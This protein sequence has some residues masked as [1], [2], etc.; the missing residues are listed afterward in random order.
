M[1]IIQLP[2]NVS[3]RIAAGEVIERPASVIRELLDNAIDANADTIKI[4]ISDGGKKNLVM[5]DNG[6]GMDKNDLRLCSLHHTTSKL[7][8]VNDLDKLSSLGFRGEAL[9]SIAAVSHMQIFSRTQNQ[10]YGHKITV[11]NDKINEPEPV[12]C[13][14]G[15]KIV[16]NE[17]FYNFPARL[18]F[19]KTTAYEGKLIKDEVLYKTLSFPYL[20]ISLFHNQK[21]VFTHQGTSNALDVVKNGIL[22]T[23]NMPEL[24]PVV[25]ETESIRISGWISDSSYYFRQRKHQYF[26]VNQRY[27]PTRLFYAAV[28]NAINSYFIKGQYP[29]LFL[30]LTIDPAEIDINVHPAKREIKF[31][32]STMIFEAVS[33]SLKQ[34]FQKYYQSAKYKSPGLVNNDFP[35]HKPL[36]KL[37]PFTES[38]EQNNES[39]YANL[40]E[41]EPN[42]TLPLADHK[43]VFSSSSNTSPLQKISIADKI[44][45]RTNME[46]NHFSFIGYLNSTYLLLEQNHDLIIIDQHAAHER[47]I[48]EE[49]KQKWDKN[50]SEN[51]KRKSYPLLTPE[52]IE[53]EKPLPNFDK[54]KSTFNNIGFEIDEYGD[55]TIILR[56]VPEFLHDNH[57]ISFEKIL[58]TVITEKAN[59]IDDSVLNIDIDK[60]EK[61]LLSELSCQKAVKK[62]RILNILEIEQL[63]EKII[64]LNILH[65][66]H[67]RP[68]LKRISNR[69][70]EQMFK[71]IQ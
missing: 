37:T 27:M 26:F 1:K 33:S 43:S 58:K 20:N 3:S 54:I 63:I 66:P 42:F 21:P 40:Q 22:M 4:E 2:K 17:L 38:E 62:G 28:D 50:T 44:T 39:P 53:L 11:S 5:Q 60:I 8:Q 30:Y 7:K 51:N 9:A 6:M 16:I 46:Q 18:K 71:R 31:D 19:L 15:T 12:S 13:A 65:C 45:A 64:K 29:I 48:Y 23:K 68:F 41:P 35:L 14:K 61:L 10:D 69:E 32:K 49:L 36:I 59:N 25:H 47:I 57:Y 56:S 34:S 24:I 67:G 55:C 70:F 52:L